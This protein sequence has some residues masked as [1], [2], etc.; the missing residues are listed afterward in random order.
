MSGLCLV[1]LRILETY[2]LPDFPGS[3]WERNFGS[4]AL[5]LESVILGQMTSRTGITGLWDPFAPYHHPCSEPV[6][7]V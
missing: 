5:C 2:N 4:Y 1:H 7:M 6:S 3:Q